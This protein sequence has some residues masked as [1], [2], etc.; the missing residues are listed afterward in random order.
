MRESSVP[1]DFHQYLLRSDDLIINSATRWFFQMSYIEMP[2]TRFPYDPRQIP[3]AAAE[4][5]A[6]QLQIQSQLGWVDGFDCR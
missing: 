5:G 6:K 1:A 3:I 2:C 4:N